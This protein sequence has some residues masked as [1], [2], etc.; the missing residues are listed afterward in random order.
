MELIKGVL[1]ILFVFA[2]FLL[3]KLAFLLIFLADTSYI[4]SRKVNKSYL[5]GR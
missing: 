5:K 1:L 3:L 2:G 4:Y